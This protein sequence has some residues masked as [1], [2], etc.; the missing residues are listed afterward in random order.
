MDDESD[1]VTSELW[2]EACW[3]V[4]SSYFEEKGLVRQQLDSFD[5]FMQTSVQRIVDDTPQIDL[6]AEAQ[7]TSG[8]IE[9][10]PQYQ[11]KFEQIYLS[12]PTHW[13]KDGAPSPMMP[14]EAR[15][16][17]LTYSSPLYVDITKKVIRDGQE[18]VVTNHQKTFL[19]KIPIML[20]S[21]YCLLSGLT[22]RDLTELN[23]CPLDPGG[24]FIINGTE[25]VIIAQERM[26]NNT[27]YVFSQKDSKYAYKTELRS[28]V[29]H[30]SR[31]SSTMWVN[32][33]AKAGSGAKNVGIGQKIVALLPY[34]KQEIPIIIVFRALGFVS[35]R[36][37]LEHIIYDFDDP[38][39]MEMVK[40]SIDEAFCV[41]DQQVALN[42]IGGRGL[43]AGVIR[44]KRVKYA[45]EILQKEMLPHV[46]ISNFC[47]TRK[48]YFL[49][50]MVHRLLL[51]ALGR[52]EVDDRDHYG[53]KRLDLAG[54]LLAYLFRG[55]FR[56]LSK[57]I[58]LYAQKFIDRGRD[59]NLE[60]AIKTRTITDGLRYSLA[61]GNWGDQKKAHQARAGV[62]Q[63]LNRLTYASTL[64]HLRRV[65]SPIG[66]DGKLARP[67]QLH[68]TQWGMICPAE[69]PEGCAVG[70]VKNLALMAYISVG[71]QPSPI[72]E[73]LEEWSMENMEEISSSAIMG[74]TKIFVNGCWVGI[75]RDPE[76]LMNTLKKLRRQ[77]DIIVSE[78]AMI[79]DIREREIRIYTDAGRISRPLLIVENQK[80]LLKKRHIDLL[81]EREYNNYGWQDLLV[82]GVVEYI[83][84][85]EEETVMVAMTPEELV[86]KGI[87]YCTTYTHCEIHPSM[88][89]G[90][91]ASI[92]P[93]P[94]HNQSPRNT[95]QS[96]MGKQA[97]GVYTT[98]YHVRMDTLAHVLYYPQKPLVT[99]RSMEYLRFSELPAGINSITAI[100]S[101]TGYNQEDSI[102][103]NESAVD[104]GFFRSVFYRSYKDAESKRGFDQEEVFE[105]PDRSYVQGMRNASYDKLDDDGIISPGTRVSGDDALIGKTITLP[106]NEDELE[107]QARRYTKRDNSVFMRKGETGVVDQ[108]MVTINQDGHKFCKIRVR[109]IK[110]PH[111]GDKF[112]S[113]HGQKGTCGM[114]YRQEDMPFTAEG[115][116]PDIIIN[117]HA[118]PSR[119]TIGH[120]IECLQGK[121][122]AN[123]GEIADAT[124]FNDTV[125]VRKI[126]DVLKGY[127][128][129]MHGNEVVYN[130]HTGRKIVSQIFIGPTYY[131]RLKHMVDDKIHSRA[132]GPVQI[133]NR[134]PMEGR[135]RD[136]GLRFGEMERDCQIAHGAAQFLKERLFGV[137]TPYLCTFVTLL[138]SICIA[139]LRN[140]NFE[141]RGC[142]NKTQ[143][144]QIRLPYACKLLFQELMSMSI[145]PRMM[146]T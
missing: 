103:M 20:R 47:E 129:H 134:Q 14:N 145:A 5:E 22:D 146:V 64:S 48:A 62:S 45:K 24:Y 66:R 70:L 130:G 118:I 95:Y 116:S 17:N 117:P 102:I 54:P 3:T 50:Y 121:V 44:E 105:K 135:S 106:E 119:M 49:G 74:A 90:V 128:Y 55:L 76:Q 40:P 42:F 87:L 38:E 59:F 56:N 81:K 88:I 107:G 75:H 33:M 29:E 61:T 23:E 91:C 96:A 136:G 78:V 39:M 18:P 26:A 68:N 79:R 30:S 133:L 93:F 80:L 65:N 97:M 63:V 7:H 28:C 125:N 10:P 16:R 143:I 46:G 115:I 112:A 85:M 99:T 111:I 127:G 126:S 100:A 15:L 31:P 92:I 41:Q 67:R 89:L 11:L 2:Q 104:R 19:G 13:E 110:T 60:L 57:E 51:A 32:M 73:F 108:V 123:R 12:K 113:R 27:V 98:N 52:R 139:N 8:H 6:Q 9:N 137:L 4:I 109:T 53:N 25:K 1:D 35:D 77:M 124:P 43:R 84:T 86:E 122:A 82:N 138:V 144:S 94:D 131:Q 72:L 37:I 71:S 101:Y 120:L 69:T 140:Q 21:T 132:R 58:R 83:D 142:K 36:D 114:K 34:I 141:C